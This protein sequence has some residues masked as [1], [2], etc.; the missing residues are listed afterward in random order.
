MADNT[1][2]NNDQ[3][4]SGSASS[5]Y[6]PLTKMNFLVTAE[7]VSGIAAFSEVTGV[8]ASVDASN[9]VRETPALSLP[10]RFPVW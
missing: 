6:Y 9:S 2:P 1:T 5:L 4:G 10:L 7:N 3:G 8:D